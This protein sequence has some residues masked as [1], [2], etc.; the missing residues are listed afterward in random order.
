MSVNIWNHLSV[1]SKDAEIKHDLSGELK[2]GIICQFS[3]WMSRSKHNL[4][5]KIRNHVSAVS[6][7][8]EIETW[9]SVVSKDVEIET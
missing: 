9:W 1:F 7:N 6:K 4:S 3:E 5:V 2:F 8:V